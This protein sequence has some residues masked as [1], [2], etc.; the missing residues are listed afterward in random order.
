MKQA[1]LPL[2][3]TYTPEIPRVVQVDTFAVGSYIS[4]AK[5][6]DFTADLH[7]IDGKP[8]AKH[9]RT[10]GIPPQINGLSECFRSSYRSLTGYKYP[11]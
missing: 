8:I 3:Q 1:T 10:P 11:V 7:E 5:P 6:I 4:G 2:R 9:G